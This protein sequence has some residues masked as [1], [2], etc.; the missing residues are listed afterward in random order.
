MKKSYCLLLLILFSCTDKKTVPVSETSESATTKGTVTLEKAFNEKSIE[1]TYETKAE[2]ND[3]GE[4]R[5]SLQIAKTKKGYSYLLKTK[6]S[7]L[8][9]IATFKTQKYGEKYLIL[10]GIKWA[11]YEGDISNEE[12]ND[13]IS[14]SK[15]LEIPVGISASYVKDTL[16]I[17]NYGNSMNYY[18]KLSDCDRKYI[19]LIKLQK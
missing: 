14:D 19:Q 17:Q 5:L 18:T 2:E 13:S 12:E 10:E 11:E 9:G 16:T 4:C 1:G 7:E 3:S 6:S 8:K 15:D